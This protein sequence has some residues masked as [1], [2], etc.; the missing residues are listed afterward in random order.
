MD[1]SNDISLPRLRFFSL[2]ALRRV[3]ERASVIKRERL[4]GPYYSCPL[5]ETHLCKALRF[6]EMNPVRA[7]KTWGQTVE[8]T[9]K[10]ET[11]ILMQGI[12]HDSPFLIQSFQESGEDV[13]QL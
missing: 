10:T 13:D 1:D 7:H 6:V 11:E 8:C 9:P 5:D 12:I 4:A 3:L 2:R